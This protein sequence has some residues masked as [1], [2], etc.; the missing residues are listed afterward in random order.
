[1]PELS[2]LDLQEALSGI[3][4]PLPIVFL[5]GQGEIP[6]S[7]KAMRRG[8]EDFLTKR[9]A[10]EV[11]IE[12]VERALK[13]NAREI[14]EKEQL[15]ERRSRF[16]KLSPR[17][18]EVLRHVIKGKMNK[19]IAADLGIN[20]RTVKLHRTSLTR[21]L[22]VYSTAELTLLTKEARVFDEVS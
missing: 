7:V 13:R 10:K 9:V 20:E 5:T 4:D 19:E 16:E 1:M 12:A 6:D 21:K 2:G 8:A 14:H 15:R 3:P 11:L 22:G 18:L 17:E